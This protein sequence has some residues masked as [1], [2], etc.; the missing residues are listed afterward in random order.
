MAEEGKIQSCLSSDVFELVVAPIRRLRE[1]S[2]ARDN[3][4]Q[5][6]LDDK[7]CL[8]WQQFTSSALDYLKADERSERVTCPP[9]VSQ[10]L[11]LRNSW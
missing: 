5:S 4:P 2:A 3:L 9:S 10:P 7:G 11:M 1:D 6:F 8:N